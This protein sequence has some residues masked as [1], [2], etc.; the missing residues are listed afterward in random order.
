MHEITPEFYQSKYGIEESS[1]T[2]R[3]LKF[4][5]RVSFEFADHVITINEPILKLLVGRG[6][7]ADKT[8]VI[9]NSVDESRFARILNSSAT[10]EPT[11]DKFVMMY[12][13]TLTRIYGLD[14]AVEA[15]ALCHAEMPGAELWILGDG[16]DRQPLVELS[17]RNG[18]ADKVRIIGQVPL[19]EIPEWL[20]Q[21][22]VGIL[23]LRRDLF[24]DFA[25]PNKLAE[26]II[27]NKVV[28]VSRL[29]TIRHYFSE[30][31]FAYFEPNK[32]S[33]LAKQLRRIYH[34]TSLRTCLARN[35]RREYD[36]IRWDLMKE[37]Y[38]E[39]VKTLSDP[40]GRVT[41][42]DAERRL[43]TKSNATRA[44]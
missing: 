32:P 24:L 4:L 28:I 21:C 36:P 26:F 10:C 33:D 23:P 7:D 20:S 44:S 13:G 42:A 34:D 25:F 9:M 31:A 15:F 39:V 17:H 43:S 41:A 16:P 29:N 11:P 37:R 1:A 2:I 8:T 12:H 6:L 3:L 38:L 19:N 22:H 40:G 18:L 35:A 5:E 27:M 14:I 30:D